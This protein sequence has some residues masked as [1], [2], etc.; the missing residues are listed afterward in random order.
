MMATA[1]SYPATRYPP[2][3]LVN[4]NSHD[5]RKRLTSA[6]LKAFFKMMGLW[7]VRDEDAKLLLGGVSNGPFYEMKRNPQSRILSID[8]MYRV[9]YLFGIFKAINILHRQELADRWARIPNAGP[10]FHGKKPLEYMIEGG[11]TALRDV[12]RLL[13][14]QI[15]GT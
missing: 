9:S 1:V 4:F 10:P 8:Q 12:R 6:S 13:E 3:P 2:E 11:P 5:E 14:G 15:Q 7:K